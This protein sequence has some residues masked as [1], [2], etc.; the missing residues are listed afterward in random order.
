MKHLA[1]WNK[2]L[3]LMAVSAYGLVTFWLFWPYD[4]IDIK[5]VRI[6]NKGEIHAGDKLIYEVD[7]HKDNL[8]PVL[9]VTHQIINGAVIILSP[10]KDGRLPVGDHTVRRQV[11]LPGYICSGKYSFYVTAAYQVNPLRSV[12]IEAQSKEF[13]IIGKS[14]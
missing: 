6:V 7:Y 10:L 5:A 2:I 9:Y 12:T 11:E 1:W 3:V 13:D 4:P 14:R 8:Y